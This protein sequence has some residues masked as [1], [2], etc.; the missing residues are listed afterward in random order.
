MIESI[1]NL[2]I[3]YRSQLSDLGLKKQERISTSSKKG[4][5]RKKAAVTEEE[6]EH[7]CDVCRAHL[8]ISM[9]SAQ[10]NI[11]GT[12]TAKM[13]IFCPNERILLYQDSVLTTKKCFEILI[14]G[15]RLF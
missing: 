1:R 6:E 11:L 14:K 3:A 8:P 12:L 15:A 9:V 13:G 5:G 7:E 10:Y 2:E 4:P